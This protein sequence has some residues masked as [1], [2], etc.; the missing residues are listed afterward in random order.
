MDGK[1]TQ[2]HDRQAAKHRH[3]SDRNNDY[4]KEASVSNRKL[5]NYYI[6]L[7][8]SLFFTMNKSTVGGSHGDKFFGS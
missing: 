2:F 7:T 3:C 8:P 6:C 4:R 5:V 1:P